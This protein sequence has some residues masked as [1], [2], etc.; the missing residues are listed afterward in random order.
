M[1]SSIV[2]SLLIILMAST[3]TRALSREKSESTSSNVL[4]DSIP[5]VNVASCT[6]D[7]L[8]GIK[9][10]AHS[11]DSSRYVECVGVGVG[12]ERACVNGS[13]FDP[14]KVGCVMDEASLAA[15]SSSVFGVSSD[16]FSDVNNVSNSSVVGVV[17]SVRDNL[18]NATTADRLVFPR[19][20]KKLNIVKK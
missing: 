1:F 17:D 13:V 14:S 15:N 4:I 7:V 2:T 9:Y 5:V 10:V 3:M 12:M 16:Q 20:I 18:T 8:N 6:L 19:L 11:N